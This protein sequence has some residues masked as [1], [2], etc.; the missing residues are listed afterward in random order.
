MKRMSN[1]NGKRS[2]NLLYQKRKEANSKK[3]SIMH[4]PIKQAVGSKQTRANIGRLDSGKD[5]K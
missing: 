1:A 3:R 4:D 2:F 5:R